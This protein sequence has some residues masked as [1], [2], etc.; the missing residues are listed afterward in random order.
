MDTEKEFTVG[1]AYMVASILGM[2]YIVDSPYAITSPLFARILF[3]LAVYYLFT[4]IG[5]V[6][7]KAF[8][9]KEFRLWMFCIFVAAL[10]WWGIIPALLG[11]SL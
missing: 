8:S 7:G 1:V 3:A 9:V 2:I 11:H 5:K 4:G 6:R 10:L